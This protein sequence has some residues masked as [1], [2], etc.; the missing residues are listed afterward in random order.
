MRFAHMLKGKATASS[1]FNENITYRYSFSAVQFS[2]RMHGVRRKR[3][4]KISIASLKFSAFARA[5]GRQCAAV[6]YSSV[7]VLLVL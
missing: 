6:A 5:G 1:M 2:W 4:L 7:P 3:K